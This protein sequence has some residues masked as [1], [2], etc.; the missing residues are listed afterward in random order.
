MKIGSRS[1]LLFL[2][3]ACIVY[4]YDRGILA[5]VAIVLALLILMLDLEKE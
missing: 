5:L 4:I 1:T 2:L 3:A